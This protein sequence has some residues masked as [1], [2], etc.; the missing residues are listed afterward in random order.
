MAAI[1]TSW[2]YVMFTLLTYNPE[3]VPHKA[4]AIRLRIISGKDIVPF[5]FLE[6][7]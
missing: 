3:N 5:Y 7:S 1:L 6:R 2:F 4:D